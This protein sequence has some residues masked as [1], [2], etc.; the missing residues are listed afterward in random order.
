M[1]EMALIYAVGSDS[2]LREVCWTLLEERLVT[3]ADMLERAPLYLQGSKRKVGVSQRAVTL[4]AARTQVEVVMKRVAALY[5]DGAL[6]MYAVP[7]LA[8]YQQ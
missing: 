7:V 1:T 3:H 8:S 6:R 5:G 4:M 2:R